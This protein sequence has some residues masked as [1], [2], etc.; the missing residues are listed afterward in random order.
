[1]GNVT[2]EYAIFLTALD[3]ELA[4]LTVDANGVAAKPEPLPDALGKLVDDHHLRPPIDAVMK[5]VRATGDLPPRVKTA[6]KQALRGPRSGFHTG[7]ET[8][9]KPLP[10]YC[11][12]ALA[13]WVEPA[14]EMNDRLGDLAR[15]NVALGRFCPAPPAGTQHFAD[16]ACEAQPLM[17][18]LHQSGQGA[19]ELLITRWLGAK[20]IDGPVTKQTSAWTKTPDGK[21]TL[22]VT[23]DGL[24]A[25]ATVVLLAGGMD[26]ALRPQAAAAAGDDGGDAGPRDAG[27][28]GD[29]N[30]LTFAGVPPTIFAPVLQLTLPGADGAAPILLQAPPLPFALY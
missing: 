23:L 9:G 27:P 29:P 1:V 26:V 14:A 21:W 13:I 28:V 20:P 8:T 12:A 5:Y 2:P 22:A 17:Q 6:I 25:G 4:T 30:A 16:Y 24:P 19:L 11:A 18:R 3:W 7:A 15:C 10:A